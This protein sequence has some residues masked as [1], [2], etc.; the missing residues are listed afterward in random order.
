[1]LVK[2]SPSFA[3][4]AVDAALGVTSST[5][6]KTRAQL[7]FSLTH[8]RD[9]R[10]KRVLQRHGHMS[11]IA[12]EREMAAFWSKMSEEAAHSKLVKLEGLNPAD[13]TMFPDNTQWSTSHTLGN[14]DI[15]VSVGAYYFA[16]TN[17]EMCRPGDNQ[18]NL[19][20]KVAAGATADAHVFGMNKNVA[21]IDAAYVAMSGATTDNHFTISLFGHNVVQTQLFPGVSTGPC[22]PLST[23]DL[24]HA[25]PG[26]GVHYTLFVVVIPVTFDV[27][28]SAHLDLNMDWGVCIQDIKAMADIRPQVTL[29]A[30]ASASASVLVARAGVTVSGSM[31][32]ELRPAVWVNLNECGVGASLHHMSQGSADL[33]GWYQTRSIHFHHWRP[34][35]SWSSQHSHNFWTWNSAYTDEPLWGKKCQLVDNA[36]SWSTTCFDYSAIDY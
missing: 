20:Y 8:S 15:G 28:V 9:A 17:F 24:W 18:H 12:S 7:L 19:N 36:G 23:R 33:T 26:W 29:T 32:E 1:M 11:P 13:N 35:I 14:N 34:Q 4:P 6:S 10:A 30:S 16:G 22:P 3:L 21:T 27:G 31:M 2:N 25:A 5:K